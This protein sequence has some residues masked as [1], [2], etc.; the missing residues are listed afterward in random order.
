MYRFSLLF[1]IFLTLNTEGV[2]QNTTIPAADTVFSNVPPPM[3][4]TETYYNE[5]MNEPNKS[6]FKEALEKYHQK[7]VTKKDFDKNSWKKATEGL[8]YTVEKE[9]EKQRKREMNAPNLSLNPAAIGFLKW[10]F[11][12]IAIGVMGYLIYQFMGEG[13][14]F[15]RKSRN[16]NAPSVEIDLKH[17]ACVLKH[18][19]QGPS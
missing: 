15:G 4:E 10:L 1:F 9:K 8:D 13:N 3:E 16:I 7:D 5:E 14:V 17:I 6:R 11:I 19:I 12:A 18:H 2:S